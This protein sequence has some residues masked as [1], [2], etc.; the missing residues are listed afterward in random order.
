[1]V[2][3]VDVV[4]LLNI[5]AL[6]KAFVFRSTSFS[7]ASS[8]SCW[9]YALGCDTVLSLRRLTFKIEY[10]APRPFLGQNNELGKDALLI[11]RAIKLSSCVQ[12]PSISISSRKE[13]MRKINSFP[14]SLQSFGLPPFRQYLAL[15]S[16]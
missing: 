7:I 16:W 11:V 14:H 12:A 1:M 2:F 3:V 8:L 5:C 6:L 13:D 15:V 10:N 9:P 4:D